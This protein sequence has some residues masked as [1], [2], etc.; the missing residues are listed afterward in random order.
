MKNNP[1]QFPQNPFLANSSYNLDENEGS[2]NEYKLPENDP[3]S[4]TGAKAIAKRLE[5]AVAAL[6]SKLAEQNT[7]IE[8]LLG[9]LGEANSHLIT[10]EQEIVNLQEQLEELKSSKKTKVKDE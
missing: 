10:S 4:I 5:A 7:L 9:E 2:L 8:T 1:P 6:S 3:T